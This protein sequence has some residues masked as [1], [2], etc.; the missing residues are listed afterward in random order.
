MNPAQVRTGSREALCDS[1][2][3]GNAVSS[4]NSH[5]RELCINLA[6]YGLSGDESSSYINGP[7]KLG[8]RGPQLYALTRGHIKNDCFTLSRQE[9]DD[10]YKGYW[11]FI[12]YSDECPTGELRGQLLPHSK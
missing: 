11:Y 4:Y 10:L 5:K 2:A 7:A 9:E 8:E 6:Y 12:I 1:K 3:L